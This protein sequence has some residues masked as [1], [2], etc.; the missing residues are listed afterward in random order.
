MIKNL[1]GEGLDI[2]VVV[3][4]LNDTADPAMH[5]RCFRHSLLP[6]H[7][8]Q[9]CRVLQEPEQVRGDDLRRRVIR[10]AEMLE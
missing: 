10:H 2:V 4:K 7:I 9:S 1:P 5:D 6:F 8:V 3:A